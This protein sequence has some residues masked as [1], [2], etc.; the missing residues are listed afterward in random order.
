MKVNGLGVLVG[1][2]VLVGGYAIYDYQ[3]EQ[4][5][6]KKKSEKATLVQL[7]KDQ[8]SEVEIHNDQKI[9]LKRDTDG[10]VL[11]EP[12]SDLADNAVVEDFIDGSLKEKSVDTVKEG[13]AID[14]KVYGLDQPRAEISFKTN[15][16][17]TAKVSVS[18]IKNYAG[19]TYLRRNQDQQV[20]TGGT[21][22]MARAEKKVFDFRDKRLMRQSA[23]MVEGLSF[24][25][26]KDSF[27]ILKKEGT[28]ISPDKKDWDIDASKVQEVLSQLNSTPV[29]EILD[30][31]F[32]G[33]RA[34]FVKGKPSLILTVQLKDN[35]KWTGEIIEVKKSGFYARL[36]EKPLAVRLGGPE[37]DKFLS[38]N[39]ESFR[40]KKK[41]FDFKKDDV[42]KIEIRSSEGNLTFSSDDETIRPLLSQLRS[43]E[44]SEFQTGTGSVPSPKTEII[45]RD[46]SEKEVFRLDIQKNEK[47]KAL[48]KTN[49]FS[50]LFWLDER[51]VQKLGLKDLLAKK[52]ESKEVQK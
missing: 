8:I 46:Q 35:K 6:I 39:I 16:G 5:D 25:K 44:I 47:G 36:S 51:S 31:G 34:G 27:Q 28:W 3:S 52:G 37:A 42:K 15:S 43:L 18:G 21:M 17:N 41:A 49:L 2:V 32:S 29:S 48:A 33:E 50:E 30:D 1:L 45:L 24:Q 12:L 40:D 19:E 10:W 4:S 23:A 14:W 9:V 38:L 20:L 7:N 13:D 11:A 26:G 22:W